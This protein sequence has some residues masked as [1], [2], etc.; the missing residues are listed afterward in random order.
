MERTKWEGLW[1]NRPGVYSGKVISK[2]SIPKKTRLIIRMNKY[3][4]KG[5]SKPHYVYCFADAEAWDAEVDNLEQY[6]YDECPNCGEKW[7]N[8]VSYRFNYCPN[9]GTEWNK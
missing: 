1:H 4:E 8:G 6:E 5:D 3:H 7:N 9:C 2:S